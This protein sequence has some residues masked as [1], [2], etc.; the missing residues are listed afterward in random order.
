MKLD[1]ILTLVNLWGKVYLRFT[2]PKRKLIKLKRKLKANHAA[3]KKVLSLPCT[4]K[5]RKRF[6]HLHIHALQLCKRIKELEE[7]K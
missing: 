2:N 4:S 3:Q 7:Y 1:I 6:A 5:N